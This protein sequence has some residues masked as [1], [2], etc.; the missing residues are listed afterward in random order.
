MK[1]STGSSHRK[2]R[3]LLYREILFET[4]LTLQPPTYTSYITRLC[5]SL[6]CFDS[7]DGF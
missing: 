6:E 2:H 1:G 3:L 5:I 4:P 7:H